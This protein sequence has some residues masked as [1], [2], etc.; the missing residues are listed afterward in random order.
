MQI[1]LMQACEFVYEVERTGCLTT[2][3]QGNRHL[4]VVRAVARCTIINASF[5][6]SSHALSASFA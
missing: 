1:D 4:P 6:V 3:F 5:H 2:H